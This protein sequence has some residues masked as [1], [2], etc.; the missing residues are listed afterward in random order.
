M[1]QTAWMLLLATMGCAGPGLPPLGPW[2]WEQPA[3]AAAATSQLPAPFDK[4]TLERA[5]ETALA[6]NP[7]L[8]EALHLARAA[9]AEARQAGL[10]P[11]P[12]L[13][14]GIES[15]TPGGSKTDPSDPEQRQDVFGLTQSLPIWGTRDRARRAAERE[16]ERRQAEF[17]A[18]RLELRSRVRAAFQT[19]LYRQRAVEWHTQLGKAFDDLA[20][21]VAERFRQGDVAEVETIRVEADAERFRIEIDAARAALDEARTALAKEM[22]IP[23]APIGECVGELPEELGEIALEGVLR[24]LDRHPRATARAGRIAAAEAAVDLAR[25]RGWAEPEIGIAFRR[26][27]LTGQDTYDFMFGIP[28]PI[29]DRNQG[30]IEAAEET[31]RRERAAAA[32]ERNE[33]E[34][35]A[36][37]WLSRYES[38]RRRAMAFRERILPRM[39][40]AHAIEEARYREGDASLLEVLDARRSYAESRLVYLRELHEAAAARAA[41]ERLTGE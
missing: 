37:A 39:R 1:K 9:R 3:A 18:L 28:I 14:A 11:N 25:A 27:D 26:Y 30:A 16:A 29:F 19:A 22:G 32:A 41:L 12:R 6:R 31:L 5:I 21:I 7:E 17:E 34:A 4:L 8:A 24:G 13:Q 33:A 23:G 40:E 35:E 36:R 10:W 2:S 38:A 15:V 20:V